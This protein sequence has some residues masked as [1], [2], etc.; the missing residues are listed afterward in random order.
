MFSFLFQIILDELK[1]LILDEADRM[2][3]LGFE[4]DIRQLVD[5]SMAKE[6]QTLMFSATFPEKIQHLARDFLNDYL[7]IAVGT[8]GGANSDITQVL[9]EVEKYGK[10]DKLVEILNE[11]SK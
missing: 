11:N 3:D 4:G 5:M 7:F 2:L 6:R 8:V 1:F 10:R 9:H